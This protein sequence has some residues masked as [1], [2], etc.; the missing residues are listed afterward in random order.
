MGRSGIRF[1]GD[2][3]MLVLDVPTSLRRTGIGFEGN[4]P[5]LAFDGLPKALA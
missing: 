2:F 3:T 1:E 4:L 5:I